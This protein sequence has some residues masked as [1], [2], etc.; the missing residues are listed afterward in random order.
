MTTWENWMLSGAGAWWAVL[1]SVLVVY[2][3]VTLGVR[4]LGLRSFSKMSSTDFVTSVAVG[5][6][7]ATIIST[8]SPSALIGALALLCV[9]FLKWVAAWSRRRSRL[10]QKLLDNEPLYLMIGP[11]ILDRNLAR[12]HISREEL[13]AKLREANVWSYSQVIGV[14]LETTGDVCV[15]R[16]SNDDAPVSPEIFADIRETLP[17][18]TV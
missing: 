3:V 9:F 11:N 18:P 15:L 10:A 1:L 13:H 12:T 7:M 14:V 17:G 16:K 6:L 4:L 2:I 5:S 8:P